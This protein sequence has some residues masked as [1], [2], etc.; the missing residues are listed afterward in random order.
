MPLWMTI[1]TFIA[2]FFTLFGL[3][4]LISADQL[5]SMVGALL[6]ALG[7]TFLWRLWLAIRAG[8]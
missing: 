7:I 4:L 2:I 8:I 1:R 6:A 5:Q 3:R